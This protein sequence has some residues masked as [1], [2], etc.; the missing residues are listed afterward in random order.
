MMPKLP[1]ANPKAF[2]KALVQWFEH[3]AMDYPWR[4]TRDPWHILIS[5]VM[6]QQTQVA[7]VLNKGFYTNFITLFPTPSHL[8]A[9]SEQQILSAWE[10]LGY[11]RRVRNLQRAAIAICNDFGGQFPTEHSSILSL[12]GIGRYTAGAVSSFAFDQATAI[13]DANV[14]RVFSRLFDYQHRVDTTSGQTQLWHWADTLIDPDSPRSYNSALMELGQKICLNQTPACDA[15]PVKPWCHSKT[16]AAL[17]LKKAPTPTS[18]LDEHCLLVINTKNQQILLQQASSQAR[19]SGMW[20]LPE[21]LPNS[22]EH[23]P[24]LSKSTYAITHHRVTLMI[25]EA[26]S[27][28]VPPADHPET[29]TWH[30]LESLDSLPMPSP[31]RKALTTLL[32]DYF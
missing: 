32:A 20:K 2:R 12:P 15:C 19:R 3:T 29:E 11:Y 21:R 30:S 8:A 1:T 18:F 14:A 7:T 17:P 10:G 24:L 26:S 13:V 22:I 16:P 27:T 6:L 9:A 4:R 25:Y 28:R 5:E 31:F 23:L